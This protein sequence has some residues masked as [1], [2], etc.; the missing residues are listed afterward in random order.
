MADALRLAFLYPGQGGLPEAP[1]SELFPDEPDVPILYA[2]ASGPETPELGTFFQ[3]VQPEELPA[4]AG[5][6]AT[7]YALGQLV[8]SRGIEPAAMAGYSSGV[9]TALAASQAAAPEDM[10]AIVPFAYRAVQACQGQTAYRMVAVVGLSRQQ[11]EA[12]LD[13]R[14]GPGWVSL[15]NNERQLVV[16]LPLDGA[17]PF[18]AACREAGALHV[19]E[20]PFRSPYHAPPLESAGLA[21]ARQL[22]SLDLRP[23]EVP[24]MAGT[25]PHFLMDAQDIARTVGEQLFS[26]VRWQLTIERLLDSGI[27]GLVCLDPSQTLTRIVLW[28]TRRVPVFGLAGQRD[29]KKLLAACDTE[30]CCR[31]RS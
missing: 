7:G 22:A 3:A 20:L 27:D 24:V 11:V 15:I 16:S 19:I 6:L 9:Y 26:P 2:G 21:L 1:L 5:V 12:I 28:I 23:P 8:R 29:L 13:D 25:E 4:Q 30:C 17:K 14:E 31:G 10:A 18:A